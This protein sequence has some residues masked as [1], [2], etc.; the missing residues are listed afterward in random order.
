MTKCRRDLAGIDFE[1]TAV[2]KTLIEQLADLSLVEHAVL[3]HRLMVGP[4]RVNPSPRYSLLG[5]CSPKVERG[6]GRCHDS[7]REHFVAMVLAG[8]SGHHHQRNQVLLRAGRVAQAGPR[9]AFPM[10][11]LRKHLSAKVKVLIDFLAKE[12]LSIP[13]HKP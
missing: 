11:Q 8:S 5:D 9:C 7:V 3:H 10:V 12:C 6:Q 2:D 13:Y 1:G 4:R